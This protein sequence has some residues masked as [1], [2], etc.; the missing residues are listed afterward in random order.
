MK[1]LSNFTNVEQMSCFDFDYLYKRLEY[2]EAKRQE[3]LEKLR[4]K[5]H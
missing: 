2:N 3:E 1:Y 5:H 4:K